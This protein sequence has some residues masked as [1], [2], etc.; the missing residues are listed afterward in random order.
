[1]WIAAG[2]IG[3][4]AHEAEQLCNPLGAPPA[5]RREPMNVKRFA[6]DVADGLAGI[7][8]GE[9]VLEDDRHLAANATHS[10]TTQSKDVL[11]S[12]VDL[13]GRRLDQAQDRAPEGRLAAARLAD[14]AERLPLTDGQIHAIHRADVT[15]DTADHARPDR[16]PGLEAAYLDQR[17]SH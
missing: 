1:M 3:R 5:S 8:R 4:Q 10:P 15:G 16:K 7:E 6:E 9:G 17:F 2:E 11:A 13:T 12:E 14:Q